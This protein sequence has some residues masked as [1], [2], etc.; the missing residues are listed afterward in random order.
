[1]YGS[2]RGAISD[3][4]P[5]RDNYHWCANETCLETDLTPSALFHQ[6]NLTLPPLDPQSWILLIPIVSHVSECSTI[7]KAF[8]LSRRDVLGGCVSALKV[9]GAVFILGWD[10]GLES[11]SQIEI[12][13]GPIV[14]SP[15]LLRVCR[16]SG[17]A[18]CQ[19]ELRFL[20][21]TGRRSAHF[22]MAS[23]VGQRDWPH[24]VRRYSTFGG[25][26]AY[27]VRT[28]IPSAAKLRSCCPSIF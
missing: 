12:N 23:S 17:V 25:T 13:R 21:S 14:R 6:T 4:R 7:R 22:R 16:Y 1:M 10:L 15:Q 24:D 26:W 28:T 2:V 8:A 5:Y 3:G 27:A 20:L 9:V 18:N 11:A 19:R